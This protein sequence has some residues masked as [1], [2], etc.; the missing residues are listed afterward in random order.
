MS[1]LAPRFTISTI[2]AGLTT[3]DG[4]GT[5]VTEDQPPDPARDLKVTLDKGLFVKRETDP[6]RHHLAVTGL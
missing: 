2:T 3:I 6:N 4:A 5:A 1:P